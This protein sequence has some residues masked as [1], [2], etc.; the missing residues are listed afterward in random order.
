MERDWE[1]SSIRDGAGDEPANQSERALYRSERRLRLLVENLSDIL[2]VLG[3]D[4][5][6]LYQSASIERT[7]GH[8]AED[9]IGRNVFES[10]LVHPEDLAKKQ[11]FFNEALSNPGMD[12]TAEFR[13]RHAGG[14]WRHIEAVGKNLIQDPSVGGIVATYRDITSRKQAEQRLAT[15]YEVSR[16]L[17]ESDGLED[18]APRILGAIGEGLDWEWGALWVPDRDGDVLRC[19][20]TWHLPS[21]ELPQF[22]AI[23]RHIS[24]TPSEG[25]PGRAWASGEPVWI[26][27]VRKDPNFPRMA[28]ADSDGLRAALAFPILLGGRVLGV[29]EFL[30]REVRE[31]DRDSL[32]MMSSVGG[33]IGQFLERKRVEE[34]VRESEARKAAVLE[35]ALDAIITMDHEGRVV[36]WNPAAERTFGYRQEEALGREMAELII[37]PSLRELHRRGLTRYLATGEGPAIGRRLE[38]TAIRLGGTEF[39]VELAITRIASDGPPVFTGYVRDITERKRAEQQKDELLAQV[40]R[41]LELRNQFLSIASHE[42]RTP[43]TLLKGYAQVLY[44]R[45]TQKADM[46]LLKPLGVISRQTERIAALVNDL[47]DVSRIEKGT[48]E[49]EMLPFDLNEALSQTLDETRVSAPDFVFQIDEKERGLWVRGDRTRIQQ[50]ISNLV[51]NAV[52]YS[53]KSKQ[54]D[55]RIGRD[56]ADAVVSV[57]DYGI[58]IPKEQQADVFRLYFRGANVSAKHYGGLGLGLFIS[59]GIIERHGGNIRV[60]SEEGR[61]STF[62]FSLPTIDS[63][64]H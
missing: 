25:L 10:P 56:G 18:A 5:T 23:S 34:A 31:Q 32:Q 9:Q 58:G 47:L 53:S 20:Q 17:S 46:G 37:P 36:E 28:S 54:V 13:L 22:E 39:P 41:A 24:F 27:D 2:T 30:S 16:A 61:G 42:L 50:V 63:R 59:K 64:E 55:V 14:W 26:T 19:I 62:Y 35:S 51:T 12:V 29:F 8:T 60:N 45:A 40:E 7:L 4:G 43:V 11:A 44:Q 57:T 6:I 3:S 1:T 49:F 21:F 48:I 33:Q 52:K 38:L 15:Q